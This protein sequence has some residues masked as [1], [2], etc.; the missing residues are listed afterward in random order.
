MD[1]AKELKVAIKTGKVEIGFKTG[2]KTAK[3]KGKLV[4][5][6]ANAPEELFSRMKAS[7]GDAVPVYRYP[8]SSWD[9]GGLCGK[10]FPVSTITVIDP[11]ESAIL[12][13]QEA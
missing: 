4:V 9:L 8:G 11:G 10:P 6:A 7:I 1:L 12:S 3:N 5:M 13:V 2:L